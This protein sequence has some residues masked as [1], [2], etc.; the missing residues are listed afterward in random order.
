VA[1]PEVELEIVGQTAFVDIVAEGFD[2]GVRWGESLAQDMVAV[3]ISGPQR[4]VLVGSPELIA[5]VGAPERPEDLL[6]RPCLRLRYPSGLRPPME[7]ERDGRAVNIEPPGML[8]ATNVHL[9]LRAAIDGVGFCLTFEGYAAEAIADGRLVSLLEDWLPP[10]PGP[11]L[12]Y[13]SRRHAPA[14]LRA[15]IDFA[16]ARGKE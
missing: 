13:P 1:Y 2:A 11:F 5:R 6:T 16:R 12:Y 4:Y 8:T 14:A 3:S 9:K 15:F 7:F 10:F